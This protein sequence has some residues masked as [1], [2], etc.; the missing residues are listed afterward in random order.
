MQGKHKM[1]SFSSIPFKGRVVFI[2]DKENAL[3]LL[4]KIVEKNMHE[5]ESHFFNNAEEAIDFMKDGLP[6][7]IVTDWQMPDI[8]GLELTKRIVAQKETFFPFHFIIFLTVKDDSEDLAKALE[9]GAHDYIKKPFNMQ[10]LVARVR[11]GLRTINLEYDLMHLNDHLEKIAITDTL[12][13]VFNRRY[14]NILLQQEL[15]KVQR[16]IQELSVLLIDIDYFKKIND[17]YGHNAGDQVIQEVAKRIKLA[18]RSYDSLVRWGGE[19]F[20]LI[21]PCLQSENALDL[22]TRILFLISG[23]SIILG[24][25]HE[26]QTTISIGIANL[27]RGETA[28]NLELI[29]Q[30]DKALYQ[31]KSNGRNQVQTFQ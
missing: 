24:D 16:N 10:E 14:G 6:T 9:V 11:A 31:A 30:A 15:N 20:L 28:T 4:K 18:A 26:I 12:T 25:E 7:V 29:D 3:N 8:D 27:A 23:Q 1:N 19:E 17:T 2:D 21:C 13:D 5:I 22:A